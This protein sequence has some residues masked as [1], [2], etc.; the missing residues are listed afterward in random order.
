[1]TRI[2]FLCRFHS[3]YVSAYLFL[4]DRS[5]IFNIL[6]IVA[7]SAIVAGKGGVWLDV[8]WRPICR[9]VSFYSY[10]IGL[11]V[12]TFLDHSITLLEACIMVSSYFVYVVFMKYNAFILGKCKSHK[13]DDVS[14]DRV[15]IERA[16][17][18]L[19]S[20]RKSSE[21]ESGFSSTRRASL[22][23]MGIRHRQGSFQSEHLTPSRRMSQTMGVRHRPD[24]YRRAW[25]EAIVAII[26]AQKFSAHRTWEW[27][28]EAT[29]SA[30]TTDTSADI[31]NGIPKVDP[32]SS[33]TPIE[34]WSEESDIEV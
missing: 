17:M 26:A 1:M 23:T 19:G 10:S 3:L 31:E 25:K 5:A 28:D 6:V 8:D 32:C 9:D 12:I 22:R 34:A 11:L 20:M 4:I 33:N 30:R 18:A 14:S 21:T 29:T 15:A 27:A 2:S 13:V 16:E 24:K 7:L